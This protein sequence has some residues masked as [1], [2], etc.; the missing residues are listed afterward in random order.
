MSDFDKFIRD[1]LNQ[2]EDDDFR[3]LEGNWDKL[4]SRLDVFDATH[5][6][7]G[8]TPRPTG[9]P[10][11]YVHLTWGS[12]AASLLVICIW[13]VMNQTQTQRRIEAL[14]KQIDSLPSFTQYPGYSE[15]TS[16]T[17]IEKNN[18]SYTTS[19]TRGN[20]TSPEPVSIPENDPAITPTSNIDEK[21]KD[22]QS[23][24]TSKSNNSPTKKA[25]QY[26]QP[27]QSPSTQQPKSLF[28]D[29]PP[30]DTRGNKIVEASNLP[31]DTLTLNNDGTAQPLT[32]DVASAPSQASDSIS[33]VQ[34]DLIPSKDSMPMLPSIVDNKE[35]TLEDTSDLENPKP[36]KKAKNAFRWPSIAVGIHGIA[37]QEKEKF[38]GAE[39]FLG[40]GTSLQF[41]LLPDKLSLNSRVEWTRAEFNMIN[42]RKEF[43]YGPDEIK[44]P[45]PQQNKKI[46]G[47][48]G[49]T[50]KR[51]I[52]FGLAYVLTQ[53]TWLTPVVEAGYTWQSIRQ[54]SSTIQLLDIPNGNIE[55]IQSK[56]L[57]RMQGLNT[58]YLSAGLQKQVKH[59]TFYTH[60]DFNGLFNGNKPKPATDFN[61]IRLGIRYTL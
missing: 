8:T 29:N 55:Q 34:T 47:L 56:P 57:A 23:W 60:V 36:I 41:Q 5:P 38:R 58:F 59:F 45:P 46:I 32:K 31:V 11:K 17:S 22:Q 43:P 35:K 6:Q 30:T 61:S 18:N 21:R 4:S 15:S 37:S 14:E 33:V 26:T 49:T 51:S 9:T 13:L 24:V 53:K 52:S 48:E 28:P 44:G 25:Q 7:P 27:K 40:M 12:I 10:L 39:P 1:Q 42:P 19:P 54:D 50:I 20:A 2:N 3:R 16:Q